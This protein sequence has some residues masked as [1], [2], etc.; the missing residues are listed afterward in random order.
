ML[1]P[2]HVITIISLEIGGAKYMLNTMYNYRAYVISSYTCKKPLLTQLLKQI[3][4]Y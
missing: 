3:M 4:S 1:E 2:I